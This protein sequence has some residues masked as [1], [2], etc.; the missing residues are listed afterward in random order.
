VAVTINIPGAFLNTNNNNCMIMKMVGM[1][2]ELI[3]KQMQPGTGQ[4]YSLVAMLILAQNVA[5][6]TSPRSLLRAKER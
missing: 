3:V 4:A 2:A 1:L 6:A 5:G